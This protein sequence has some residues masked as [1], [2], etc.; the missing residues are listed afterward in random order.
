MPNRFEGT[1]NL[2]DEIT[3]RNVVVKGDEQKVT[4]LRVFFDEYKS[5]GNGGYEQSGGFWMNVTVWG[6]RAEQAGNLLN[7]GSRVHVIG[8]LVEQQWKDKET[9]ADRSGFIVEADEL[10]LSLAKVDSV[11]YKAKNNEENQ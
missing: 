7:K 5:D 9:G 2:G 6:R 1:G 4:T 8:R 11:T 10:Y 3:V